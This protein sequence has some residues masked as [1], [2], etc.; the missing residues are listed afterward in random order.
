MIRFVQW[1]AGRLYSIVQLER[2]SPWARF[3]VKF[4]SNIPNKAHVQL[5]VNRSNRL[6]TVR[7]QIASAVPALSAFWLN[8]QT[9]ES[10]RNESNLKSVRVL[11]LVELPVADAPHWGKPSMPRTFLLQSNMG[12]AREHELDELDLTPLPPL[13]PLLPI[14]PVSVSYSVRLTGAND[15]RAPQTSH[16]LVQP[17][18][19]FRSIQISTSR[20]QWANTRI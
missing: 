12:E 14:F 10:Q 8:C 5:R 13:P 4:E 2:S 19:S 9:L 20:F 3:S 15:Y 7:H 17:I 11:T 6:I 16:R 1:M 18:F